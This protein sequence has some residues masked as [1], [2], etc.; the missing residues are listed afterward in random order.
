MSA[1]APERG[2]RASDRSA[3]AVVFA[4]CL[5][6]LT[7]TPLTQDHTFVGQS[8][9]LILIIGGLS[10]LLRRLGLGSLLVVVVQAVVWLI[11]IVVLATRMAALTG[12]GPIAQVIAEYG[13]A[14]VHMRDQSAP[15]E[16]NDGVRLMLVSALGLIA[17]VADLLVLGVDRPAF[18]IAPLAGVYLVPALGLSVDTGAWPLLLIA[19]GYLAILVAGGLN[20]NARWTRGLSLDTARGAGSADPVVWR[21]A[22][23]IGLPTVVLTLILGLIVPT[24]SLGGIGLGS[25][26]GSGNGPIQLNDPTLDLKRNLTQPSDRPLL[27]YR[28]TGNQGQYLRLASLPAFSSAG[29]QN[30]ESQVV[31]GPDFPAVPGLADNSGADRTTTISISDFDSEYLPMPYAPRRLEANGR[32]SIDTNSLVVISSA[33]SARARSSATSGLG[34]TVQSQDVNPSATELANAGVGTPADASV[35]AQVPTDV[36]GSIIQLT[37]RITDG[38]TTPAA[39]AAAI[40]D[41]LRDPDN[42]TYSTAPQ[43]GN[44]YQALT[45]F[46]FRDKRGYC[47]QFAATMALMAR[48]EGIPSRVAVGFLPG[49]QNGDTWTISVHDTHA[50]PEL[51]FADYGWVRYEPTPSTVT[52]RA[53]SWTQAAAQAAPSAAPSAEASSEPSAPSVAPADP[54]Q[55]Q[56]DQSQNQADTTSSGHLARTLLIGFGA[57]LVLLILAAPATIRVRRR[58]SRFDAEQSAADQVEAAWSEVRDDVIDLGRPWPNGSPRAIGAELADR[59]E[60]A[61]SASVGQLAVLVERSRYARSFSGPTDPA[62]LAARTSAIRRGLAEP[63]SRRTRLRSRLLPRSVFR[64]R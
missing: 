61:E 32:W 58:N 49:E 16:P 17:I 34:Y 12:Q 31:S 39:R 9:L 64:R 14:V 18:G 43:P 40:Q 25:G 10:A 57:L 54:T 8:W 35:T 56:A 20:A 3:I 47:E 29:W 50:W 36:P 11:G 42:F 62:E 2:L 15:M 37:N 7:L 59:L 41:Y 28:T 55:N 27:S 23:L 13:A 48:I 5:A 33:R 52:G 4:V 21:A 63:L 45:N 46:L 6:A 1:A 51:Y 26:T 38:A 24:I 19:L 53:P 22:G 60:P 30:S 44:G